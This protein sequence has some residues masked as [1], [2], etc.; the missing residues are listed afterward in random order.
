MTDREQF[1]REMIRLGADSVLWG[2]RDDGQYKVPCIQLAWQAWQARRSVPV[3]LPR[4]FN[5][6]GFAGEG[7]RVIGYEQTLD[8]IRAAGYPVEGDV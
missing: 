1:E 3:K 2:L 8:A 4:S 5:A 7:C 6:D